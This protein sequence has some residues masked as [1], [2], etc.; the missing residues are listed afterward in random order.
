MIDESYLEARLK[1]VECIF[2]DSASTVALNLKKLMAG[3]FKYLLDPETSIKLLLSSP[4]FSETERKNI[5]IFETAVDI[6]KNYTVF[7]KKAAQQKP[8]LRSAL[9]A[10]DESLAKMKADGTYEKILCDH[11]PVVDTNR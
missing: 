10:F 2:V 3:R 4:E 5:R 6:D 8:Y 7:S 1:E 11:K 9:K